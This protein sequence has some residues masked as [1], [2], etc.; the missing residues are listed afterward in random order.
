MRRIIQAAFFFMSLCANADTPEEIAVKTG[1]IFNFFKFIE[2]AAE[3]TNKDSFLLCSY[4]K[5]QI[6]DG[7]QLLD[8][9]IVNGKPLKVSTNISKETLQ[10]CHIAYLEE[11]NAAL[12]RDLQPFPVVTIS[13]SPDFAKQGGIIGL[14]SESEHLSFEINLDAAQKKGLRI[15][16]PMLKLAKSVLSSK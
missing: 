8:G 10:T 9:K 16:T 7:L 15:S 3:T 14:V 11:F 1:F 4:G 5:G 6:S 12:L 2:W 13:D